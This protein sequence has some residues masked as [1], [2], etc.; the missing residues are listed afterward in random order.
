MQAQASPAVWNQIASIINTGVLY[1][2]RNFHVSATNGS[3]RP[4]CS[5]NCI[6]FIPSTIF[7]VDPFDDLIIPMHKSELTPLAEIFDRHMFDAADH[8][9]LYSTGNFFNV[10]HNYLL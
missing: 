4:V 6:C 10:T 5:Q 9:P 8:Q 3:F 1:L 2:I 7:G